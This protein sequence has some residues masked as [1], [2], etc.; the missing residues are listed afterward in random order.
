MHGL[1]SGPILRLLGL[2]QEPLPAPPS[3]W[4]PGS[5][6]HHLCSPGVS[7]RLPSQNPQ[8]ILSFLATNIWPSRRW[9]A[10]GYLPQ[11]CLACT[12]TWNKLGAQGASGSGVS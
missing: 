9:D 3:L 2:Y 12:L 5:V 8:G 1:H 4:V 10:L 7:L 11:G 6:P